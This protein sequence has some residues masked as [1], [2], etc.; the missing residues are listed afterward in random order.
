VLGIRLRLRALRNKLAKRE[1][2]F[3]GFLL[4]ASLWKWSR[5]FETLIK[6]FLARFMV[7]RYFRSRSKILLHE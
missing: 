4:F 5:R 6:E 2:V 7:E 1:L 3:D